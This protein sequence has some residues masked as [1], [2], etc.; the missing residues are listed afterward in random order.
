[1]NSCP[2]STFG[3][4]IAAGLILFGLAASLHRGLVP[5]RH[6]AKMWIVIAA[7][8]L[9]LAFFS[10]GF[11]QLLGNL[12]TIVIALIAIWNDRV[13]D[14]FNPPSIR[15]HTPVRDPVEQEPTLK[16]FQGDVKVNGYRQY[17]ITIENCSASRPLREVTV[18]FRN[19]QLDDKLFHVAVPRQFTWAPHESEPP[20]AHLVNFKTLDFCYI[21][22]IGKTISLIIYSGSRRY[23]CGEVQFNQMKGS[24]LILELEIAA[25]NM[26]KTIRKTLGVDFSDSTPKFT[27]AD[28][29]PT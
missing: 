28:P 5:P 12:G 15:I 9:M 3:T 27:L 26:A 25:A 7:A 22:P 29:E 16:L 19:Y 4:H 23:E 20:R 13:I 21:D 11:G 1:M 10:E 17:H 8:L 24:H 14:F 2:V 18:S 6:R